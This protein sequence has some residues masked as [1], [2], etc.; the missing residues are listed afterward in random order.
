MNLILGLISMSKRII[1]LAIAGFIFLSPSAFAK[2]VKIMVS[3]QY[4]NDPPGL[5][6]L[7]EDA[8]LLS[9]RD[10]QKLEAINKLSITGNAPSVKPAE[11]LTTI[12]KMVHE[13]WHIV[14]ISPVTRGVFI[15]FEKD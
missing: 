10:W 12:K 4:G 6:L 14:L 11:N 2:D 15:V 5:Y 1:L 3:F 9:P 8:D 13:G 7:G